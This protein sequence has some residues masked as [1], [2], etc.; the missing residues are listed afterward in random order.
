MRHVLRAVGLQSVL[1]TVTDGDMCRGMAKP[2]FQFRDHAPQHNVRRVPLP[3]RPTLGDRKQ[4]EP[5]CVI[6]ETPQRN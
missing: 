5:R 1:S 2:D 3:L 6:S 4:V